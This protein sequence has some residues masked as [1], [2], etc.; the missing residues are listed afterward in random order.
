[1]AEPGRGR[2]HDAE[3]AREAILN[4]AE[5]VFAEHGFD[6]AR[7]AAIAA[8]AGY[9]SSLIFQY[10][11]DK[12][13]LYAE[14]VRRADKE[15]T[16]LQARVLSPLLEDETIASN[17]HAFKALLEII[18][19]AI[20]DYLAAHPHFMRMLLWEQAE[21]WKT[22]AKIISQFETEDADQIEAVFRNAHSAGLLHSDFVPLIQLTMVLQICLSYLTFIPLYQMVRLPDEDLFS[23][24][25]LARARD[26]I[27][28]F[29]VHGMMIDS[30]ETKQ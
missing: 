25:A 14:V 30:A 5:E 10:F 20:F 17:A 28:A 3:G 8:V 18:A 2:A 27:V 13:G 1:M 29:V 23:P 12:L 19:T 16:E 22:Y 7:T 21:G 6:G 26:Y 24:A 11:G 4:A 15:M 9:N